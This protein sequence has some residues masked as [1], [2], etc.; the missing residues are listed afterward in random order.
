MVPVGVPIDIHVKLE[1]VVRDLVFV[2]LKNL[3]AWH[4]WVVNKPLHWVLA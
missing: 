3:S 2:V 1:L 4:L